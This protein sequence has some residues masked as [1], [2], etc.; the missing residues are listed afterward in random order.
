MLVNLKNIYYVYNF[1]MHVYQLYFNDQPGYDISSEMAVK[2]FGFG[3]SNFAVAHS[4][5]IV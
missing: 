3:K 1:K 2:I 5:V 4:K